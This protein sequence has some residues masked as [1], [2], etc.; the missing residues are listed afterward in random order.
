MPVFESVT[1]PAWMWLLVYPAVI[2]VLF[3]VWL[4]TRGQSSEIHLKGFGVE[5][6]M[7]ENRLKTV[8]IVQVNPDAKG[9]VTIAEEVQQK[10]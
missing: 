3:L 2:G 1:I 7:R 9:V 4:L 8:A 10:V 6:I 5:L